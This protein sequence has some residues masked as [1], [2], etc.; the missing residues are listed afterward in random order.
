MNL[1]KIPEFLHPEVYLGITFGFLFTK[2]FLMPIYQSA[3][4]SDLASVHDDFSWYFGSTLIPTM[5]FIGYHFLSA[6]V[7]PKD[8]RKP[9]YYNALS[10]IEFFIFS[11]ILCYLLTADWIW[12]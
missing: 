3:L 1:K 10:G 6:L 2:A 4:E 5:A 12:G 11:N 8:E 9:D 7:T